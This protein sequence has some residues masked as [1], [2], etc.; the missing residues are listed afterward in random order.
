VT[1]R[2][3][4]IA[5]LPTLL[6]NQHR[7]TLTASQTSIRPRPY[8]IAQ[9][10]VST[11]HSAHRIKISTSTATAQQL[12]ASSILKWFGVRQRTSVRYYDQD[13]RPGREGRDATDNIIS[14]THEFLFASRFLKM[15]IDWTRQNPYGNIATS[16]DVYPVVDSLDH[17]RGV[18]AKSSVN[19]IQRML[20][21]SGTL[22]PFTR[23]VDGESL[24]HVSTLCS[25][26]SRSL[27]MNAI[28]SSHVF[29]RRCLPA[30]SPIWP[31]TYSRTCLWGRGVAT[32]GGDRVW[33]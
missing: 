15:G 29:P 4:S 12:W 7:S 22:H 6:H 16:L 13:K 21:S 3:G 1:N 14:T 2:W 20:G 9:H 25:E 23:D 5:A 24:L 30:P 8:E 32:R 26:T 19:D 27:T 17:V 11:E 28:D 33:F 10:N 18:I 31:E